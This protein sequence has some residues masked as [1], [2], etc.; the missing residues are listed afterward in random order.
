MIVT[1]IPP[2]GKKAFTLLSDSLMLLV[3]SLLYD[4]EQN[5]TKEIG[6]NNR[7]L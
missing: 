2:F 6:H 7:M 3:L 1:V 4:E 5:F